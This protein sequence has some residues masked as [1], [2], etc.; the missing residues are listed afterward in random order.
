MII[1]WT[2]TFKAVWTLKGKSDTAKYQVYVEIK[3]PERKMM[4]DAAPIIG[5][6]GSLEGKS[7]SEVVGR[8]SLEAV[9][10]Y[11]RDL[12]NKHLKDGPDKLKTLKVLENDM[13]GAEL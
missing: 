13:F 12:I 7:L 9:I 4:V 6:I 3:G 1:N 5:E 2:Q 8:S 11:L 10:L